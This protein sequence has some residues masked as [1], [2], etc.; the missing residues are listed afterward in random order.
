MFYIEL[1]TKVTLG[2][3]SHLALLLAKAEDQTFTGILL[4]FG[5]E[6]SGNLAHLKVVKIGN[7]KWNRNFPPGEVPLQHQDHGTLQILQF[8]RTCKCHMDDF[9]DSSGKSKEVPSLH[10]VNLLSYPLVLFFH[11]CHFI[12]LI[13]ILTNIQQA[14]IATSC[15][16]PSG[17]SDLHM[18]LFVE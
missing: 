11:F 2:L 4:S 17:E 10:A 12:N 14:L 13:I 15:S 7:R 6:T 3:K 5:E 9:M 8:C 16:T 1:E 18:I